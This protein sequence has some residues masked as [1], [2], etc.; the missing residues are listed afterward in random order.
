MERHADVKLLESRLIHSGVAF[1]VREELARLPSGLE[2][3]TV[4]IDHPGAVVIAPVLDD[5]SILLVR[6]YRHAIGDWLLE[7]PAGRLARG[8]D[9]LRAAQRELEEETGYRARRWQ[10]LTRFYPAPG[11]CSELMHAFAAT[12]LESAGPQRLAQDA[13]EELELVRLPADEARNAV[14]RDA[15]SWIVLTHLLLARQSGQSLFS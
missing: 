6:Q 7:L 14:R 3:R 13:D 1:D 10:A 12:E 2:Q 15:K 5:G 9:P 8:E 4:V 11:F